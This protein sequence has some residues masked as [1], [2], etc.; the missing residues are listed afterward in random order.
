[1]VKVCCLED[2]FKV[3]IKGEFTEIGERG[4]NISGGQ[5]VFI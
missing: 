2:D 4:L 3:M 1:V 5:K